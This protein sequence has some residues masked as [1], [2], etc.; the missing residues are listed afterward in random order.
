VGDEEAK[1]RAALDE[2]Q[3]RISQGPYVALGLSEYAGAEEVRAAFLALTKQ[4]HPARFGRMSS[5][6]QKLS[7]EVFLGIKGAHDYLQRITGGSA[8]RPGIGAT[9]ATQTIP[10]EKPRATSQLDPLARGTD[11]GVGRASTPVRANTPP[12]GIRATTPAPRLTPSEG[13]RPLTPPATTPS[14]GMQRPLTPPVN[15]PAHGMQRPLTPP[16]NT[17]AQGMQR[18]ST[19]SMNTPARP[20]TPPMNTPPQGMPRPLT[21]PLNTPPHGM[22]RPTTPG[23]RPATPQPG[24]PTTPGAR[25][26]TPQP[27]RPSADLNPGTVRGVQ[28]AAAVDERTALRECMMLLND[29]NWSEARQALHNLAAKVPQAKSYRALLCYAR[30]REAQVAGRTDEARLEYERALQLDPQLDLAHQAIGELGRRR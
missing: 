23:A 25:P 12:Q 29:Q 17:P 3:L 1:A 9:F 2:M 26:A 20:L 16:V 21:P 11:R 27:P 15:T 5:E 14:H 24:R 22:Q 7:N 28:P 4:F 19:P 10:I 6:M 8:T 13:M 18:P 30:G